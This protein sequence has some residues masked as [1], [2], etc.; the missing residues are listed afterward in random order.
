LKNARPSE[1]T[2]SQVHL[3][4]TRDFE[5]QA[6][7]T[8]LRD[9]ETLLG[10]VGDEGMPVTAGHVLAMRNLETINRSLTQPVELHLK[11]AMQKSYPPINGLYLL[12]RSTGLGLI[13]TEL[14]KPRLKL[15][16]SVL[17]SWR[18]LNAAERYFAL[19]K[20][21][22]GRANEEAIGEQ[23]FGGGEVLVKLIYFIES[24]PKAGTLTVETPQDAEGLRYYP[25]LH[26]LA[27]MALFGLL[28][29]RLKPPSEGRGWQPEW[30]RMT[31]W[32]NLILDSYTAFIRQSRTSES[33]LGLPAL[34]V[35]GRFEPLERFESWSQLIR[36]HIK[37]WHRDLAIPEPAF[38]LGPHLFKVSWGTKC[39]RLIAIRGD[40]CLDELAMAILDAFDFDSD[41]LYRFS[42]KDRFG[43]TF[44]VDHPYIVR[45][46]DNSLANEVKVGD[47]P[48]HPGMGID[49]LYDFG[50][51]WEFNIRT[52]RM[53]IESAI[54]KSQIMETHG[55][56]P[57][58]YGGW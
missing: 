11:R 4:E 1:W 38:Q 2:L 53:N 25:G 9:V 18:S 48:L 54:D 21:W 35:T 22:W 43:R 27:L 24:F 41:H 51:Q 33:K 15:D 30:M 19:L 13:D 16:A 37:G 55:K 29:I 28:E 49:F 40:S 14:K 34:G 20:A 5:H 45:D 17:E 46:S 57:E 26:N 32:G 50:E 39:W 36:P 56:A 52:E 7:G 10:L 8:V 6:P 42:Y 23:V 44:D 58:Q 47:L 31:D 12:L 3:L